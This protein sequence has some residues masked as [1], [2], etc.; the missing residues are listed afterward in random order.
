MSLEEEEEREM[1]EGLYKKTEC[2]DGM[3]KE[4]KEKKFFIAAYRQFH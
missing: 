4:K 1:F 3:R 2:A